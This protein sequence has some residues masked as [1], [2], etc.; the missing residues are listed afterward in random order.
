ML[1]VS[2][3][4]SNRV[5]FTVKPSAPDIT[6]LNPASGAIGSTVVIA[7]SNFGATHSTESRRAR[8]APGTEPALL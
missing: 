1:T 7:G 3:V 8:Q 5:A 4:A 6:G 2:G